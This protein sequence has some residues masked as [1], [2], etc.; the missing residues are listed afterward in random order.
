MVNQADKMERVR[1]LIHKDKEIL[2]IDYSEAK[3]GEMFEI[4]DRAKQLIV[5]EGK[6]V[7][8][9]SILHKNYL[10]PDFM[11][12]VKKELKEVESLIAKNSII[13]LTE[14]QQW[15]LK[16]TNVWY[17]QQL[18]HFNSMDEALEFLVSDG[19]SHKPV[20]D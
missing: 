5:S 10:T 19:E 2:I 13:G 4:I 20:T 12:H 9:M 6:P 17:K 18:F 3:T 11:K 15:I 1:K 8:V 14:I 7:L 16:G